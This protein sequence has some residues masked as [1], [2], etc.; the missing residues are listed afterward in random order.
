[1]DTQCARCGKKM[2]KN[3]SYE[4]RGNVY[5]EDCY[6]D[7]LSPSKACDPWAVHSAKTFLMGKDKLATLTSQQLT[8]VGYVKE[9]KEVTAEGIM[10]DLQLSE[11]DFKREFAV[12]RHMEVLAAMKKEGKV[13]YIL[14]NRNHG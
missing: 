13:F 7:I 2:E 1:M 10:E 8:I 12:L 14:F 11:K 6:M 4:H 3:Q 9:K 5:C